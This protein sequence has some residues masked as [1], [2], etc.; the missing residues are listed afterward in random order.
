MTLGAEDEVGGPVLDLNATCVLASLPA[1][2]IV[3][4]SRCTSAVLTIGGT[5]LSLGS[6]SVRRV[7][8]RDDFDRVTIEVADAGA[9]GLLW[10]MCDRIASNG[11]SSLNGTRPELAGYEQIPDRGHYTEAARRRRLQW[12]REQSGAALSSLESPQ[13]EARLVAGNVENMVGTVEVPVGLAGPMLFAGMHARGL[14][15]APL[16]TTEGTLVASAARG[17]KAITRSGG[18]VTWVIKQRMSRAPVYEFG[19]IPATLRFVRWVEEHLPE[20]RERVHLVSKRARLVAIE[21]EQLGRVVHLR[22]EY[23]TGDAAGQNMTTACTWSACRWIN[24]E[25]RHVPGL[26]PER[27]RIEGNTNGDKKLNFANLIGT[28]GFRVA[29]ECQ[30]DRDTLDEVLKVTPEAMVEAY[31]GSVLAAISS[32]TVGHSI[33]V[34][35]VV[36]AMFTATG[37]DIACAHESG[38]GI[39]EMRNRDGGLYASMLLPALVVGTVGGGT[40]LPNQR[41][42]LEM[43]GCAG[44]ERAPR[45]AEIVA[46]FALALDLSTWAAVVSGQFAHAHERLG[47]NRPVDFFTADGLTPEFFT[48]VLT[49][50][51]PTRGLEVERVTPVELDTDTSIV[52]EITS[53]AVQKKLVG[54]SALR[55]TLGDASTLEV[56]VKAKPLGDEVLLAINRIASLAGGRVADAYARWWDWV[57]F[58]GTHDRE[59]AVYELTEPGIADIRPRVYGTF[60]DAEREAYLVVMELLRDR[61]ILKDSSTRPGDWREEHVDAALTGIAGAHAA[62]LGREQELLAAP[63][64]QPVYDARTMAE[65]VELWS[66]IA[67]HNAT[68][69]PDW[70]DEQTRGRI[71]GYLA[72]VGDWWGELESMPRTLVHNDFNPRNILLRA[73]DLR[74]VAYDWELATVHVPQRDLAELLAFV[75]HPE[76]DAATVERYAE[77]HRLALERASG[78]ELDAALWWRG[79]ELALRDFTITRLGLYLLAHTQRSFDFL[80]HVV[81]T[82]KRLLEIADRAA[83]HA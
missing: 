52:T 40:G 27:F 41:D 17:A 14:V 58:K 45:F 24:D 70:V 35:N 8:S 9:R 72:D 25:L 36:A 65:T 77:T 50:S 10:D 30:I 54:I 34:A 73:D 53:H 57:G 4:G 43:L 5:R 56:V 64:V 26:E 46:G 37:Q 82:T 32:G 59:L 79:F 20:I 49:P 48:R 18:A 12:I 16:A 22:F 55:L 19:D 11:R 6:P 60:R 62:F 69:Y 42:Y 78:A 13:L 44:P 74:L 63:W 15:T 3:E 81:P 83:A 75:L 80:A 61:V 29:A 33:N 47:R 38:T 21:P 51:E 7:E 28:R 23:E 1:G 76:V 67:E 71:D 39:V 68:E 31:E 66:A 2:V